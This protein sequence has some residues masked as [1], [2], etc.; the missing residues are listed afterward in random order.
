M[1]NPL[2]GHL[3]GLGKRPGTLQDQPAPPHPGTIHLQGIPPFVGGGVGV[4]YHGIRNGFDTGLHYNYTAGYA[5]SAFPANESTG[6]TLLDRTKSDL[7]WAVHAGLAYAV[8]P[9]LKLELAY[10]YLNMGHAES[11][12]L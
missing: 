1:A 7:A 2:P 8:T 6:G 4:A 3:R 9:N 10:R 11:G 12:K 5:G